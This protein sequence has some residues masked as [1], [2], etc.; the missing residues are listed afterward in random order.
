MSS[1]APVVGDGFVDDWKLQIAHTHH[2]F[3]QFHTK[4]WGVEEVA[5]YTNDM[6]IDDSTPDDGDIDPGCY[7]LD[8]GTQGKEDKIWVRAEYTRMFEFAETFYAENV[9][10]TLSP[11]LVITGQPGIGELSDKLL[12]CSDY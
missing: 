7:V 1:L 6:E 4:F 2:P 5:A 9:C 12:S 10:N 8:I 11:C 3:A